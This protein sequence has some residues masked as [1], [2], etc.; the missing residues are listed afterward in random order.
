MKN[1]EII[2]LLVIAFLGISGIVFI[3]SKYDKLKGDTDDKQNELTTMQAQKGVLWADCKGCSKTQKVIVTSVYD[4]DTFTGDI[5]LGCGIIL[6]DQKFRLYN[7]W[8]DE[9]RGKRKTDKGLEA[10]DSM[11]LWLKDKILPIDMPLN[12]KGVE[13]K[14]KYGRWLTIVYDRNFKNLNQ[15]LIDL[16]LAYYK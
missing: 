4:G 14:G 11:R 9:I 8:A 7:T 3:P 5:H 6:K 2:G 10:R 13:K 16:D 15:K 1:F 12:S